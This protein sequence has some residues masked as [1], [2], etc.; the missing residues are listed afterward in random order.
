MNYTLNPIFAN[1][2]K[3]F[4]LKIR[5]F[6]N[7][8]AETIHKARNELKI[9]ESHN[10]STVVK[11]FKKPNLFN[12]IV[13]SFFRD[14]KAKKSYQYSL[15][16]KDFVPKPISYIEFYEDNLL[17]DSYFISEQFVYDFTIREPLLDK[18]FKDRKE[19]LQAFARFTLELHDN[20]IFHKDYSPGN[21]LIKI[22]NE[23]YTF[24][25]VDINRMSFFELSEEDRAKNFSKLWAS[26][27]A[28]T[29]IATEYKNNFTCT[30]D[31]INKTL[32]YSLQNKKIKNFKKWLKG[33]EID[34]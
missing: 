8:N 12:R 1:D 13:Y 27:E 15:K 31:F 10:I 17:N 24:K 30:D 6:F 29:T 3:N 28:L 33:K 23:H 7:K 34:W 9:I 4:T 14:S 5:D 21:I 26:E 19:I 20:G 11:S 18:N 32:H 2:F 22:E 16:I 25:I